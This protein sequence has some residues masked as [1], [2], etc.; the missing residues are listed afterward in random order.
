MSYLIK[1]DNYKPLL[2]LQQ[3][4]VGIAKI[5]DFFQANLLLDET[6]AKLLPADL[7]T[8]NLTADVLLALKSRIAGN[9]CQGARL[10]ASGIILER[11]NDVVAGYK[12]AGYRV[13]Q[14][15]T[16]GHWVALLLEMVA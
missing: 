4:E 15:K 13:V 7:I 1:P 2:N 5:K 9:M 11:E 12:Q 8:A 14:H 6:W 16:A 10:I 3:T